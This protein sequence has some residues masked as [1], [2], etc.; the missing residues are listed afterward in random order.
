MVACLVACCFFLKILSAQEAEEKVPP[1]LTHRDTLLLT[2]EEGRKYVLHP[3]KAKH[4]LF[5]LSRYY[6]ISLSEIYELNPALRTEMTLHKGDKVKMPIPNKAIRRYKN[7]DFDPKKF[8]PIWYVVRDGDN[9]YQICQRY[10][11]MPVDSIKVRNRMKDNAIK[12]GRRILM[13]WMSTDGIPPDWQPVRTYTK[14][15][16]MKDRYN[17]EKKNRNE[18]MEQGICFWQKH[19]REKGDLYALHRE[20]PIGSTL[21]VVNPMFNRTIH[22]KVIGRIP[23]GYES[24]IVVIL[25]PEAAR[26]LRAQ[27]ERFFVK[28]RHLR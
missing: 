5:S 11:D 4:T 1:M 7:G 22:A 18:I 23:L 12:P 26:S 6:G 20:A 15:D 2:V 27:D 24:N 8:V 3:V 16:A 25:S 13:G 14:A 21:M 9:L 17:E 10:F 28:L 19:S